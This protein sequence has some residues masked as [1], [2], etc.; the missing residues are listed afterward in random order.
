[1]EKAAHDGL[2]VAFASVAS[3][4]QRGLVGDTFIGDPLR[5]KSAALRFGRGGAHVRSAPI[6]TKE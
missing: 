5:A 6:A 1:M 2:A 4:V 3:L